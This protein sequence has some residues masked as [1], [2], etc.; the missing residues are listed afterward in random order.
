[1]DNRAVFC[2]LIYIYTGA[3]W[4][5]TSGH[6]ERGGK[7]K[8]SWPS[9]FAGVTWR[10]VGCIVCW[11]CVI[12]FVERL[13]ENTQ[14]GARPCLPERV[15]VLVEN[16]HGPSVFQTNST[17]ATAGMLLLHPT[18]WSESPWDWLFSCR[19]E[20]ERERERERDRGGEREREHRF[21]DSSSPPPMK[22]HLV[23][24][25]T[26]HQHSKSTVASPSSCVG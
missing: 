10:V 12:A 9:S 24:K 4:A 23:P 20:R 1:M 16:P 2:V 3:A 6:L 18:N 14:C 26:I 19:R 22:P 11:T 25:S 8:K 21:V 7:R 17:S 15:S 5:F 13:T